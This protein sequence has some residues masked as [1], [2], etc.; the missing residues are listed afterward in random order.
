MKNLINCTPT[1]FITQTNKIRKSVQKWL[2]LTDIINIRQRMPKLI[3]MRNDMSDEEKAEAI[4]KNKEAMN[5]QAQENLNLMF[6]KMLEEYPE[7]TLEVIGI[8]NF[9]EKEDLDKY[10]MIDLITNT[11][12]MLNDEAVIGFFGLLMRLASKNTSN[13]AVK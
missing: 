12:E 5:A 13:A 1:E 4:L 6:D 8:I 10:K 7:Q 2:K 9:I 3:P 11:T